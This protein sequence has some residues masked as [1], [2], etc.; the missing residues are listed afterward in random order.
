MAEAPTPVEVFCCYAH[1][2]ES[3]LRKLEIHLSLLKRQG[4]ISLWH[5]RLISPG[6]NWA[7]DIDRHLATASY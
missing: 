3:W 5:D 6:T 7:Q 2:D 4:L 1:E